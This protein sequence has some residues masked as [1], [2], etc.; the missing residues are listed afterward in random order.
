MTLLKNVLLTWIFPRLGIC[1]KI[2]CWQCT[3]PWEAKPLVPYS[4]G[5]MPAKN[6]FDRGFE[7]YKCKSEH[8]KKRREDMIL[9]RFLLFMLNYLAFVLFLVKLFSR[10]GFEIL[11]NCICCILS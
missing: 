5:E 8:G 4:E 11:C 9:F 6:D 7:I 1:V 10:K 3:E 2:S